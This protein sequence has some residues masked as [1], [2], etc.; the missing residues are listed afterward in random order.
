MI[1]SLPLCFK[2][3]YF[4]SNFH[5]SEN[6]LENESTNNNNNNNNNNNPTTATPPPNNNNNNNSLLNIQTN[7]RNSKDLRSF[8]EE[9]ENNNSKDRW[10][11]KLHP[12]CGMI[13]YSDSLSELSSWT[14]PFEPGIDSEIFEKITLDSEHKQPPLEEAEKLAGFENVANREIFLSDYVQSSK[15]RLGN[16]IQKEHL[17]LTDDYAAMLNYPEYITIPTTPIDNEIQIYLILPKGLSNESAE[18]FSTTLKYIL[19]DPVGKVMK[20]VFYKYNQIQGRPLD[21]AGSDGYVFKVVGFQ[22]YL[23][24]MNFP[25]GYYECAVN[26]SREKVSYSY[27]YYCFIMNYYNKIFL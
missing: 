22:E 19:I 17:Q 14:N 11:V 16:W 6:N 26:A 5:G 23:L 4:E 12:D 1:S 9:E 7:D 18:T 21:E 10:V 3:N 13:Y 15:S 25:L 20:S 2:V 8:D 24:H 27:S